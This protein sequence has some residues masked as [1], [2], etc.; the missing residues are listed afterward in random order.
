MDDGNRD[1]ELTAA[2]RARLHSQTDRARAHHLEA[3]GQYRAAGRLHQL[4]QSRDEA[5]PRE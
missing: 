1:P 2:E 5:Q 3:L 4:A